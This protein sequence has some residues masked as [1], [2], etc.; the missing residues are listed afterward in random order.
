M[1]KPWYTP[2]EML[3]LGVYGGIF[4][5]FEVH[6]VDLP[7]EL[8]EGVPESKWKANEYTIGTNY[9]S[10]AV[11][12]RNRGL[13]LMDPR[14]RQ[15]HFDWFLW[16]TRFYYGLEQEGY[17]NGFRTTQWKEEILTLFFYIEQGTYTP[18]NPNTNNYTRYTDP[19]WKP[20]YKQY[21]LH[22][23]WDPTRKP[24]DYGII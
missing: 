8:F 18:P 22:F 20:T 10:V 19:S 21:L 3:E 2:K 16:Y 9:F 12:L 23:G 14:Q 5:S 17:V 13:T 15:R 11:T 7:D 4:F 24:S 6:R 1:F